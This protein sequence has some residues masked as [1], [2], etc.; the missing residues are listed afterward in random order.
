[1]LMPTFS[2]AV[3]NIHHYVVFTKHYQMYQPTD[4]SNTISARQKKKNHSS[5]VLLDS[6]KKYIQQ[7]LC[8]L[9]A[10]KENMPKIYQVHTLH[11]TLCK[12]FEILLLITIL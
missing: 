7:L 10:K 8:I 5:I 4:S 12:M 3:F 11:H 9:K 1:M 6:L 2:I